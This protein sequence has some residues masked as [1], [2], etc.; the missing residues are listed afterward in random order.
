MRQTTVRVASRD[1]GG[2]YLHPVSCATRTILRHPPSPGL[3]VHWDCESI[4]VSSEFMCLSPS[5]PSRGK[6][7]TD[8]D[9][10]KLPMA[11]VG[12]W[13]LEPNPHSRRKPDVNSG[14]SQKSHRYAQVVRRHIQ[15]EGDI[16][17][18]HT[19]CDST[20][21][22]RSVKPCCYLIL[23]QCVLFLRQR[24]IQ[25]SRSR[26]EAIVSPFFRLVFVSAA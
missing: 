8:F 17:D 7:K 15:L 6:H 9:G 22:P 19:N 21:N 1:R 18:E 5:P 13:K 23:T 25:N 12:S 4:H 20:Y 3:T 11:H 16:L 26:S 10:R 24:S 14:K 2:R